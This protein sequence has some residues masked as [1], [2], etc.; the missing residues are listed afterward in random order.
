MTF[1]LFTEV[2]QVFVEGRTFDWYDKLTD[3]IVYD[4]RL[5]KKNQGLADL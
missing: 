3:A 4:E 5:A 2:L 1:S